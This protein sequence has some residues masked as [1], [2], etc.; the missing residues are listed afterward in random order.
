MSGTPT[1]TRRR[2]RLIEDVLDEVGRSGRPMVPAALRDEVEAEFGDLDG[3]LLAVARRWH[4]AFVAHLDAVLEDDPADLP[5]A[6]AE[7]WRSQAR[8]HA[9]SVALLDAHADRPVLVDARNRLQRDVLAATGVDPMEVPDPLGNGGC[10]TR[11]RSTM[12]E[13]TSAFVLA[14][15]ASANR[16]H[17]AP[18][19]VGAL[20][21]DG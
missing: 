3:L 17:C 4:T 18:R 5:A 19:R 9:G 21:G 8:T 14:G 16:F 11:R 6:V 7:L 12:S 2:Y 1:P 13:T 20:R 10:P 15:L